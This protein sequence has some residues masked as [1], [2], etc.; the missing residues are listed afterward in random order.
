[1]NKIK[2][3]KT[4]KLGFSLV[5]LLIVIAIIGISSG[6]VLRGFDSD[7]KTETELEI[8]GLKLSAII[9]SQK[10][11]ALSGKKDSTVAGPCAYTITVDSASPGQ[12][13]VTG[14]NP[15][16]QTLKSGVTFTGSANVTF[17]SPLATATTTTTP[18][19]VNFILT[20]GG[21]SYTVS[22]SESGNITQ[23]VN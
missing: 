15:M 23:T 12:Y 20:K 7:Q 1:M 19:P 8:E 5:E 22:V 2:F 9:N 21:K 3:F 4:K 14:C 18:F 10:N 11:D 16:T 6:I 13:A 17:T